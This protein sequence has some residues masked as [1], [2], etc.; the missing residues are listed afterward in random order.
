M[1]IFGMCQG[2]L[3]DPLTEVSSRISVS[4]KRSQPQ[5]FN[6]SPRSALGSARE[7]TT[8]E[9]SRERSWTTSLRVLAKPT[10][11]SSTGCRFFEGP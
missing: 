2:Y 6:V 7:M 11:W 5:Q 1:D 3:I 10:T 4:T 9:G 8:M